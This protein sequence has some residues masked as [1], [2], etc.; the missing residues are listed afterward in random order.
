MS[1]NSS[2]KGFPSG[3]DAKLPHH[4][5]FDGYPVFPIGS[6]AALKMFG[7]GNGKACWCKHCFRSFVLNCDG[8]IELWQNWKKQSTIIEKLDHFTDTFVKD[9]ENEYF[10]DKDVKDF[11]KEFNYVGYADEEHL[12]EIPNDYGEESLDDKEPAPLYVKEK[13]HHKRT[14]VKGVG[15]PPSILLNLKKFAAKSNSSKYLN[16]DW[17]LVQLN[18]RQEAA[19]WYLLYELTLDFEDVKPEFDERT[20][21][22]A[23]Q[24]ASY[25]TA[26]SGGELRHIKHSDDA[27]K[28]F[29]KRMQQ[30]ACKLFD[31][32]DRR[33]AWKIWR[34]ICHMGAYHDEVKIMVNLFNNGGWSS[35][36]GGPKWGKVAEHLLRY[37]TKE[38]NIV[39]FVDG[40]WGLQHNCSI[41]FD[42]I[43]SIQDLKCVLDFNLD[44]KMTELLYYATP[45]VAKQYRERR[46]L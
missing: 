17:K 4:C 38:I 43:W 1:E 22:L 39:T 15:K 14:A 34:K 26:A 10:T 42:K 44:G 2:N 23:K 12:N 5:P 25:L 6:Y 27:V 35:A 36:Y 8:N 7:V 37:R 11:E 9:F 31:T 40:A 16:Q 33:T 41:V 19:D 45:T 21:K 13:K 20:K 28:K 3:L 18:L 30:L 46:G 32:G 24:F 29:P